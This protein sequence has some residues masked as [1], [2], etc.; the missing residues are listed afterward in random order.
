MEE[1]KALNCPIS[2][3]EEDKSFIANNGINEGIVTETLGIQ[4]SPALAEEVLVAIDCMLALETGAHTVIQHISS[5]NS[6]A[7]VRMVKALGANIHAEATPHHFT[8]T[9][10]A[11]LKYGTLAKMNPPLRTEKDRLAIIEGLKDGT[12]DWASVQ[13]G[14]IQ[15]SNPKTSAFCYLSLD[16]DT[17][18]YDVRP[19]TEEYG[20]TFYLYARR[21]EINPDDPTDSTVTYVMR[22]SGD[23]TTRFYTTGTENG[24]KASDVVLSAW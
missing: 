14:L 19:E 3:H 21:F 6:V 5:G 4:G 12:I 20:L 7:M 18:R 24:A 13:G 8:L 15:Y 22:Y 16:N 2:L 10:E 23:P 1:A 11:V 17:L 9:D